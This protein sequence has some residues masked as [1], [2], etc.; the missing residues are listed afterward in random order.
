[1]DQKLHLMLELV[2][3]LGSRWVQ[4]WL[5]SRSWWI[6]QGG[7]DQSC[8]AVISSIRGDAG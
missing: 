2:F 8:S 6:W 5:W 7:D 4:G 1:M 3:V